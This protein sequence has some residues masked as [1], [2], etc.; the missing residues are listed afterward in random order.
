MLNGSLI[1]IIIIIIPLT[2][3]NNYILRVYIKMET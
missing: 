1:I 3:I 2:Y